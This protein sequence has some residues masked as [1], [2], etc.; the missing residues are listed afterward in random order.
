[1]HN[2]H[3][4]CAWLAS[5]HKPVMAAVA[6]L[7]IVLNAC[8]FAPPVQPTPT[9][10]QEVVAETSVAALPLVGPNWQIM[11]Y[12]GGDGTLVPPVTGSEISLLFGSEDVLSG[13]AGCNDY[14]ASYE[15]DATALTIAPP[16]ATRK[17]CDEPAGV[18]EQEA[19]YLAA[20]GTTAAF[21][22]QGEQLTLHDRRGAVAVSAV[23]ATS[24]ESDPGTAASSSGEV[25][26]EGK[27][28]QLATYT[29][30]EGQMVAPL[31]DT[32]ITLVLN[33]GRFAGNAGCNTYNGQYE[34]DGDQVSIQL[35]ATTMMACAEP[36][37]QQERAYLTALSLAAAYRASADRLEILDTDGRQILS[38]R[39]Q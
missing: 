23:A 16:V 13:V 38:Y 14:S 8:T 29:D 24:E 26:A 21:T 17:T 34:L 12:N 18:M 2:P 25:A 4:S 28:W 10:G 36:I 39:V 1:M 22:I 37:M 19:A 31:P 11:A 32:Q 6:V 20:L 33:N 3:R 5:M 15:M 27:T 9:P 30:S 35:G 7:C